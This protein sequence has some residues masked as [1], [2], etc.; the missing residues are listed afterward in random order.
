MHN[1]IS[2]KHLT[3]FLQRGSWDE[4]THWPQAVALCHNCWPLQR[5]ELLIMHVW[6]KHGAHHREPRVPSDVIY[7]Q[8]SNMLQPEKGDGQR[9]IN[10]QLAS[11]RWQGTSQSGATRVDQSKVGLTA[12][13]GTS[14]CCLI[15][16]N[17]VK[18]DNNNQTLVG[19][20]K[21]TANISK[22][23][24]QKI[25]IA[26]A[27]TQLLF[28]QKWIKLIRAI[29]IKKESKQ[30]NSR[31]IIL[32]LYMYCVFSKMKEK[33]RISLELPGLSQFDVV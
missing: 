30:T 31:V 32:W 19:S 1:S 4:A 14:L 22:K 20:G 6:N 16:L 18:E 10:T 12:S 9:E 17:C 13:P 28:W 7:F 5:A 23:N 33:D 2:M 29:K 15:S 3:C 8:N 27:H 25:I 26:D 21:A 24:K 11:Q